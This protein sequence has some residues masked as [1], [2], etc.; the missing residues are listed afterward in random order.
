M[1]E[2]PPGRGQ[3][4]VPVQCGPVNEKVCQSPML[5]H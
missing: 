1:V 3:G 4:V 5:M 2:V